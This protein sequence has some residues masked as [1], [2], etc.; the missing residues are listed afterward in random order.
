MPPLLHTPSLRGDRLKHWDNFTF[1]LS[2]KLVFFNIS[3]PFSMLQI[4]LSVE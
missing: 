2:F 4:S 1:T 3:L